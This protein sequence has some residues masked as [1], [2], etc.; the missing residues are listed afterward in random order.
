MFEKPKLTA[1]QAHANE[2]YKLLAGSVK[3]LTKAEICRHLGWEYNNN[4]ERRVREVIS[5]LAKRRAIIATSDQRG[6][7]LA[8]TA[9]DIEEVKHQ[10]AEL[11]GRIRELEERRKP[12]IEFYE[13]VR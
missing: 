5:L 12:L 3:P 9:E 6:Y 2:V 11:D 13:K 7:K 10:W 8:K 4:N 1:G